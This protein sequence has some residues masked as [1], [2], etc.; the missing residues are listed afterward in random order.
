M[1]LS[2]FNDR[3]NCL[4]CLSVALIS[5]LSYS[6][7]P[8]LFNM[9]SDEINVLGVDFSKNNIKN[10]PKVRASDAPSEFEILPHSPSENYYQ[11]T[12]DGELSRVIYQASEKNIS[13]DH[14]K[15]SS[16]SIENAAP[17]NSQY[18]AD[19]RS[20]SLVHVSGM[21]SQQTKDAADHIRRD[22]TNEATVPLSSRQKASLEGVLPVG[23][24]CL[25]L[26][27]LA[28]VYTVCK[29]K[30]DVWSFLS[31]MFCRIYILLFLD[32]FKIH[33]LQTSRFITQVK[34]RMS[35]QIKTTS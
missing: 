23:D 17:P 21:S 30:S 9:S 7:S 22:L 27:F 12:V 24:G 3:S 8:C 35:R 10:L 20:N 14:L 6:L 25:F 2:D 4:F 28:F 15:Q 13:Y 32:K 33:E 29:C 26:F 18:Q 34:C 16:V 5:F 11:E 19:G 1:N 31:R